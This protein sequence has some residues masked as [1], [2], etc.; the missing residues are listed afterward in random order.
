MGDAAGHLTERSQ[1]LLLHHGLL[2]LAQVIVGLLQ[3]AVQFG[4]LRRQRHM[5]AE[6][7]QELAVTAAEGF[8]QPACDHQDAEHAAFRPQ[9]RH[10]D[11]TQAAAREALRKW[12]RNSLDV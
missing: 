7:P 9:R 12:E 4:L 6:L 2:G 3:R 5:G 11:G 1:P 8:W 10:H